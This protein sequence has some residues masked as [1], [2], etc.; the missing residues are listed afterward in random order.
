[1]HESA[2][3]IKAKWF[4]DRVEIADDFYFALIVDIVFQEQ[5]RKK[6]Q[7]NMKHTRPISSFFERLIVDL[8]NLQKK[9]TIIFTVHVS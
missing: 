8:G 1:M 3:K 4:Y 6:R 7:I 9:K 5:E 2:E